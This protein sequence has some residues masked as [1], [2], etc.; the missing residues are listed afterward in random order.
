V[1]SPFP[2]LKIKVE[3]RDRGD[4]ENKTKEVIKK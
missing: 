4:P 1:G 2:P 3:R